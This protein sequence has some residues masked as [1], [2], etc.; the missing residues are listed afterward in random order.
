MAGVAAGTVAATTWSIRKAYPAFVRPH[1][2]PVRSGAAVQP[3]FAQ[4]PTNI[5]KFAHTLPGVGKG[6]A[7]DLGQYIPLAM[8]TTMDPGTGIMTDVYTL[9]VAQFSQTMDPVLPGPTTLWGYYDKGSNA[10]VTNDRRY[11]GGVVVAHRNTPVI[12]EIANELPATP[13]IPVDATIMAGEGLSV[14]QTPANRHATHLRR[15]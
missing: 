10:Q 3:A 13:V 8:P 9:G 15:F 2:T 1:H 14:G 12:F 7:N 4:T 6:A 5:P 11:L